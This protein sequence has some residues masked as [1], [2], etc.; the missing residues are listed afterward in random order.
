MEGDWELLSVIEYKWSHQLILWEQL[1]FK[2]P[3]AECQL[4]D[5]IFW[6]L[7]GILNEYLSL[8]VAFVLRSPVVQIPS[9][10]SSTMLVNHIPIIHFDWGNK[11]LF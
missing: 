3:K 8:K 2:G 6:Q 10:L 7:L 5:F 1:V 11:V 9:I 4:A